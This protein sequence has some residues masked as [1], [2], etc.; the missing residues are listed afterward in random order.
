M[1]GTFIDTIIICTCTGLTIVIAGSWNVGLQGVNITMA[2]F[3]YGLPLPEMA[4]NVILMLCLIFFAFTTILGWDYY[5]ERC[6]EYFTNRNMKAVRVYRW[7][8]IAAVFVGPYIT[9]SAVWNIADIF[10]GL[11]AFPN[12][13]ALFALSGVVAKETKAYFRAQKHSALEK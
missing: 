8:Y 6:L 4:S 1:T 10:N 11:M 5:S 12:I 7:L 13:I 9:V 2:A 3:N